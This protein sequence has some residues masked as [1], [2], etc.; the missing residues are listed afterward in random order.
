MPYEETC[1]ADAGIKY[2]RSGRSLLIM[3]VA[4]AALG[5]HML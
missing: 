4:V 3:E 1:I 2:A 5:M